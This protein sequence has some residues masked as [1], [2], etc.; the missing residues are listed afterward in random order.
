MRKAFSIV[1]ISFV[2]LSSV[3]AFAQGGTRGA[4]TGTVTDSTG[5]V[6][7][8]ATVAII[9]QNTGLTER[10]VTAGPEG[11]FSATLL[12]VGTTDK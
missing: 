10:T 3:A 6:V 9:N 2:L 5:A 11:N 7:P 1:I 4:I 12:P 8:H